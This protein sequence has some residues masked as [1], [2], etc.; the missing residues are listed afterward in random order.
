VTDNIRFT[1]DYDVLPPSREIACLV[2]L[3][4]C[5]RW[6]KLLKRP[7]KSRRFFEDAG[8]VLLSAALSFF[9]ASLGYP[10]IDGRWPLVK[11]LLACGAA[12][13]FAICGLLSL[14]FA[15][16]RR[17]DQA[18]L[19]GLA[20]VEMEEILQQHQSGGAAPAPTPAPAKSESA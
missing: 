1:K 6:I 13:A 4:Q 5:A 11:T 3:S 10:N 18:E 20:L 12:P 14:L 15:H 2:P 16:L 8:W 9:L 7:D 19:K 17:G